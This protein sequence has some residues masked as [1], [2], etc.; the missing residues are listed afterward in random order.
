M[1]DSLTVLNTPDASAQGLFEE[2]RS[3]F[4]ANACHVGGLGD[5]ADFVDRM[6]SLHPKARHVA[7]AALCFD[8]HGV[9]AERM[10]DDGEPAGTAGKPILEL[11]RNRCVGD[12]VISVTRYFGG[13]LLGAGGLTRAYANA[14][15]AALDCADYGKTVPF[16]RFRI[17][18]SYPQLDACRHAIALSAGK[19]V[20]AQY[21]QA[22]VLVADV[23]A[24]NASTFRRRIIDQLKGDMRI[25]EMGIQRSVVAVAKDFQRG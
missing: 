9:P 20:E 4:I 5:A 22:V 10:S 8:A 11:L 12:C 16:E 17:D 3:R 23:P 6:R 13:I 15:S 2:R 24:V 21:T 14:A 19:V 7:F 18:I 25:S 1:H